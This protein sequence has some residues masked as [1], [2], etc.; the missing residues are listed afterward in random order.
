MQLNTYVLKLF[1][2][3]FNNPRFLIVLKTLNLKD[4]VVIKQ[5]LTN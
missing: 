4:K 5:Q 3:I 1:W 2:I